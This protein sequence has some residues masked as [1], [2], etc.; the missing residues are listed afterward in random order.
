ME[1]AEFLHQSASD[2]V[3]AG[4]LYELSLSRTWRLTLVGMALQWARR[5]RLPKTQRHLALRS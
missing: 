2:D 5:H 4:G 1:S 3:A